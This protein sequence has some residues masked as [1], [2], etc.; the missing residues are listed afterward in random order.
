[1]KPCWLTILTTLI[2]GFAYGS[3]AAQAPSVVTD[4]N[5]YSPGSSAC[6]SGSGF[7][8]GEA[9]RLQIVRIDVDDNDC[10]EHQPWQVRADKTGRFEAPWF[11]ST[12][13]AGATLRLTATGVTSGLT[14]EFIFEDA[15]ITSASGGTAISADTYTGAYTPLT[16]PVIVET[17]VGDISVGTIVLTAPAG[18]QFDTSAPQ[19]IITLNGD[20]N[21]KNIN[22]LKDGDTIPLTVTSNSLTFTVTTKSKGQTRNTLTYSNIRVRPTAATPLASGN[23][24][25]TGT[26]LFPNSTTNFGTLREVPGSRLQSVVSGFPTPQTAGVAGT[27]TVTEQDQFGNVV[28]NYAGTVQF[29]SSDPLAI[30]PAYYT[31]VSG[32]NGMHTFSGVTLKTVGVQ[33]ITASNTG[34]T[35]LTGTQFGIS[36]VPAAADRLVFA[37]QPGS[38]TYGSLIGPQ[39]VVVSR[40]AFGNNS[41]VGLGA[42]KV[43]TLSLTAGSGALTGTISVDI[44]T[45]AGNGTAAFTNLRINAAGTGKILTASAPG[46]NSAVST[47]FTLSP[48][49]VTANVT[50]SDKLYDGTTA[51]LIAVR[52]LSGVLGVDNVLLNGGSAAFATKTVGSGK[53]VT[54]SG[55]G[56][57]G[58]NAGNYVLA[59]TT[60]ITSASI[61]PVPLAVVGV[62]ANNKIYDGTTTANLSGGSLSGVVSGDI[63]TLGGTPIANFADKNVGNNKL[64]LVG[65][66]AI[67]GPD[68]G[69]Y[70]FAQPALLTA[71]IIP[72]SL[73]VAADD[74]SRVYGDVNPPLTLSY[75]GFVSGEDTNVLSGAAGLSTVADTNSP[76]GTYPIQITIGSLASLNYAFNVTNGSLAVTPHALTVTANDQSRNYGAGNPTLTGTLTGIQNGDNIT[77]SYSTSADSNSSAGGYSILPGMNDP[78]GKL[79][80][81]SVTINNGSLTV[82]PVALTVAADDA[83]R[84]YGEPNPNFTATISGYVNGEDAN[85][86]S[87]SLILT[88]TAQPT[89]M[90]GDYPIL[91]SG[92]SSPNYSI[93]YTAGTLTVTTTN[94]PPVLDPITNIVVLPEQTL[95]IDLHA[96]DPNGDTFAISIDPGT[97]VGSFITNIV[98]TQPVPTTNTVF[99]WR[100]TREQASTTNVITV[101]VSDNGGPSMSAVQSFTV[102]VLDYLEVS[103]P[104]TNLQSGQ[105]LSVPIYLASSDN[106][107]NL[108]FNLQWPAGYL[109]NASLSVTASAIG[110]S[111]LQD[112]GTNLT[113]SF[114]TLPG[115]VL[116]GTQ[117]LAQLTFTAISNDYS[118]VVSLP[119]E[120]VNAT[121]PDGSS[122]T[123][124]ITHAAQITVIEGQPLLRASLT[125]NAARKL[126]LY[127][128]IGVGYELQ[129]STSLAVPNGWDPIWSYV[130]TNG[131]MT[132]EVDSLNPNIFYRIFEP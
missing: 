21:N 68:S 44:G 41:T 10:P 91:P 39:P 123:N 120:T 129:S 77:V 66:Y 92:L 122:Y 73:T 112:Q 99:R 35:S 47:A 37:T 50:V 113:F 89:S 90:P 2:S 28:S 127:G 107:T 131:T 63:V 80:N 60:V 114:Q 19:P 9:V 51:T 56:L 17:I 94:Q 103:L 8:P 53:T 83:T 57:S 128:R 3:S 61:A 108:D 88:T 117:E 26:S 124:Y 42:S 71:S 81:Y 36:I 5:D 104:C 93:N 55:L 40:D 126:T 85:D 7:R 49:T 119:F 86:L 87:G 34:G 43:V 100:P 32:D 84:G 72:A 82:T 48:A 58:A 69:N 1:M 59:S 79:S 31:F 98:R 102:I 11:V 22:G 45:A 46:L 13:E 64:V 110:S 111:S 54:V 75:A 125:T 130:Q 76:V 101:R 96:S 109:A 4:E 70:T 118:A 15:A 24:T 65:G 29:Y 27:F 6:I 105:T 78:D 121:K 12:H 52:G 25:N 67:S 30:L 74:K 33:S 132:I 106:V 20:N 16:G 14:S 23:I 97:P 95:T 116:Q 18:F 115:Q 38:A 62:T